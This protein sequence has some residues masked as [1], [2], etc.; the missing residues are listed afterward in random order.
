MDYPGAGVAGL[1]R[2][3]KLPDHPGGRSPRIAR[4]TSRR[5]P[6]GGRSRRTSP[7][8]GSRSTTR[9][10]QSPTRAG[11]GACRMEGAGSCRITG[12]RAVYP[13]SIGRD[14]VAAGSRPLM[15]RRP[16]GET[17]AFG[18]CASPAGRRDGRERRSSGS[19][20]SG[21]REVVMLLVGLPG[22]AACGGDVAWGVYLVV[23]FV[24]G[25]FARWATGRSRMS[26]VGLA[27]EWGR[28]VVLVLVGLPVAVGSDGRGLWVCHGR[29]TC[30]DA[31]HGVYGGGGVCGTRSPGSQAELHRRPRTCDR[32]SPLLPDHAGA[33]PTSD[34]F[35]AV[36]WLSG[37]SACAA[38]ASLDR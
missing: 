38:G 18:A 1:R 35:A 30:R 32:A 23:T 26:L 25:R 20:P 4:Q 7:K 8:A 34:R 33:S 29:E 5:R 17:R 24:A 11:S 21:G 36:S 28:G 37:R 19:L 31:D 13:V 14:S 10:P 22:R 27:P 16:A 15:S 3:G 6:P 2:G 9:R 12:L